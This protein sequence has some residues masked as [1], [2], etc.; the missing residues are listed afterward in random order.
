MLRIVEN[1][2]VQR[3]N[4]GRGPD[5]EADT[6]SDQPN[7]G[8]GGDSS[9]ESQGSGRLDLRTGQTGGEQ[10]AGTDAREVVAGLRSYL[11]SSGSVNWR[12]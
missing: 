10:L 4:R 9:K 11:D 7:R 3:P 8:A 5:W 6:N 2:G 1:G 12:W